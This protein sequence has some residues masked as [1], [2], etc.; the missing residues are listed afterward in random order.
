MADRKRQVIKSTATVK[1]TNDPGRYPDS[2][3]PTLTLVVA[4]PRGDR[5]PSKS[6]VQRLVI[7]GRRV[8]RGLGGFPLVSLAEARDQAFDNRRKARQG[9]DPFATSRT[10]SSFADCAR[11]TLQAHKE[12]W[13]AST[14]RHWLAPLTNHVFPTIGDLPVDKVTRQHVISILRPMLD[15]TPGMARKIY[16]SIRIVLKTAQGAGHVEINIAGNGGIVA[17]LPALGTTNTEH[18]K[19]LEH[20]G[21]PEAYRGISESGA[22]ASA[23]AGVQFLILTAV[24]QSEARGAQWSEID[25]ESRTWTIPVARMKANRE[26]VVPLTDAA[27]ALVESMRGLH[28]VYV[29]PSPRTGRPLSK[30]GLH[31][32]TKH[33]DGTLHGFRSSFSTW[34]NDEKTGY[35]HETI[36]ACLAHVTGSAVSRGYNR[37]DRLEKRR[38]LMADWATYLTTLH[39]SRL[40]RQPAV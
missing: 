37:G 24:R 39:P 28:D 15:S 32:A 5:P 31:A 11:E 33:I 1:A 22:C 27:L 3:V 7:N 9:I 16:K 30:M 18:F 14:F 8:D 35:E 6:W 20:A 10:V 2:Q 40:D 36:E 4:P 25:T 21:M 13:A 26:H 19:A 17:A 12:K 29:F 38:A 23:K 34:A